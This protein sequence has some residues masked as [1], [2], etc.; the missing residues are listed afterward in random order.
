MSDYRRAYEFGGIYFFTVVLQDRTQDLLIRYINEFRQ[1][2]KETTEYYT[3]ETIAIT[4]LPDHFHLII[5]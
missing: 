3:F 5:Q 2:F 1:A 4:V